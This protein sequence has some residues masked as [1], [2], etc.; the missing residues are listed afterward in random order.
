MSD[1]NRLRLRAITVSSRAALRHAHDAADVSR[2]TRRAD[3][4][5]AELER[6]VLADGDDA[7]VLRQI[8]DTRAAISEH[9]ACGSDVAPAE[10]DL[11]STG[12]DQ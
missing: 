7:E 6:S 9:G 11:G 8:A 3:Q 4:L 12:A 2:V 10:S 5:L 1:R